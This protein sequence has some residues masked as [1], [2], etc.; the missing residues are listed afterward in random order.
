MVGPLVADVGDERRQLGGPHRLGPV[1][2]LPE[3][4]GGARH[5]SVDGAC[6]SAFEPLHDVGHRHARR[7]ASYD[8][9]LSQRV[10]KRVEEIF[11]WMKSIGGF[12]RT[13]FKG[14]ART[15][16]AAHFVGAAY[17]LLRIA[18]LTLAAEAAT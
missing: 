14:V 8:V 9:Y 15:Q 2:G 10:R 16:Q 13:R 1:A 5:G 3:V 17:N 12:G 18:K 6:R 7:M 11:G 4:S